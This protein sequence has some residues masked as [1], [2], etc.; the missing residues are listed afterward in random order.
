[1]GGTK[2]KGWYPKAFAKYGDNALTMYRVQEAA[3]QQVRNKA[4]AAKCAALPEVAAMA[5][6]RQQHVDRLQ[7]EA[8]QTNAELDSKQRDLADCKLVHKRKVWL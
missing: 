5:L 3:K 2:K 8:K 7:E 4:N 6:S 1:M